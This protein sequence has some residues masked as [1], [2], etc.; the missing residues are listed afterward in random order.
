MSVK[1]HNGSRKKAPLLFGLTFRLILIMA[2][3]A[4][5]LS[6]IS[7]FINPSQISLPLFFGLYFIPILI[8]NLVLLILALIRRS[9]SAWIPIM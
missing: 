6:Y 3:I 1:K 5:I 4:M 2:G 7:V 9:K 8:T